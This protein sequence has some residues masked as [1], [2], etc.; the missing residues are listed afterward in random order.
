VFGGTAGAEKAELA[1]SER[2]TASAQMRRRITEKIGAPRPA[3]APQK[4]V[5][6]PVIEITATNTGAAPRSLPKSR[7]SGW[8]SGQAWEASASR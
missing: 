5:V 7:R 6:D 3:V 8:R 4:S 1:N 2:T